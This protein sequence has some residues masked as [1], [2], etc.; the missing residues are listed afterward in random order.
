MVPANASSIVQSIVSQAQTN[1][2]NFESALLLPI[3]S[4]VTRRYLPIAQALPRLPRR[5]WRL[6]SDW[7][8]P[9]S[10]SL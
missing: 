1:S 8:L 4:L 9:V 6:I 7:G 3:A 2:G 5:M 10:S